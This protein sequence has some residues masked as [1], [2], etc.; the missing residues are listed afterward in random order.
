MR[1]A[2][3]CKRSE[4]RSGFRVAVVGSGAAGL[5][6]A[7]YLVC[8]GHEVDFFEKLPL[9]GG[10]MTFAIP[11]SRIPLESVLEGIEDLER[12][13]PVNFNLG[14]K[15]CCDGTEEEGD[16]LSK[17]RISP[18][19]LSRNYDAVL[20]STGTWRSRR[21]N[22][23]GENAVNVLS[24]IEYLIR[25]HSNILNLKEPEIR[26]ERVIVI[27]GGLSAIDAVEES[28]N[29]GA[30]EVHLVY[31]RTAR[32]A[33]AGEWEI[34]RVIERGAK[35]IEL[36]APK[37]IIVEG[38]VARGVEFQRMKLGEPDE[39]GRPRPIPVEGSEFTIE[40]EVIV[41]AIGEAPT[42]PFSRDCEFSEFL[43]E[44]G[45]I[46]VDGNFNLKGTNIFAAG[47]VVSGP[48]KI[49]RAVKQGLH[50][51]RSIDTLLPKMSRR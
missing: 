12:N 23:E 17:G 27:G 19:E 1:F 26:P 30:R 50:A 6:A 46:K 42:P 39:T 15:V 2:F 14:I 29:A 38:G 37:R 28:L 18:S 32:E 13:F 47:D 51:A 10:L 41:K 34:R 21:L 9:P 25:L 11:K 5:S 35:F 49:G 20:I 3:L 44:E 33:P 8:R 4:N 16:H 45:R 43:D 31:R 36:A 48:S 40:A 24:A 22:I 7:G